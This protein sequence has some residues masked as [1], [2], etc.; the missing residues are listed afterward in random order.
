MPTIRVR[1]ELSAK[2]LMTAVK[3][4]S[5]NELDKF[6]TEVKALETHRQMSRLSPREKALLARINQGL[7]KGLRTRYYALVGKMQAETISKKEHQELL[8]LT[9]EVEKLQVERLKLMVKF[10]RIRNTSLT[11]LMEELPIKTP[12]HD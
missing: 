6:V 8:R 3:K 9:D 11:R 4:L 5:P 1:A 10:S 2:D 12:S 7:P